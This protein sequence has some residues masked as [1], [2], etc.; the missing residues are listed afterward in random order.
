MAAEGNAQALDNGDTF[1]DWGVLG[2]FSE[3]DAGGTS[4]STPACPAGTARTAA[5]AP[6]GSAHPGHEPHG[7]RAVQQRRD[8]HGA[9]H[10]GTAPRRSPPGRCSGETPRA[11]SAPS[12]ARRGTGCTPRS[13]SR[14]SWSTIRS[15][16]L[17]ATGSAI[18]RAPRLAAPP[19]FSAQP[20]SQVVASGSTVVFSVAS[21]GPAATYQWMLNGSPLSDGAS[22]ETTVS[23][24]AGPPSSSAARPRAMRAPTPASRRTRAV[25]DERRRDPVPERHDRR[26]PA[27]QRL[28]P[29]AGRDGLQRPDHRLRG[30]RPAGVRHA[31]RTAPGLRARARRV[32][33]RRNPARPR[34]CPVRLRRGADLRGGL[35]R[36]PGG[37]GRLRGRRRVPLVRSSSLD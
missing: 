25:G 13:S 11:A 10:T 33:R 26:G 30:G 18:G 24:S 37:L 31:T 32:R 27:G 4:S 15:W 6:P 36:K 12:R 22:G 23:G 35:G 29:G 9:R 2:R 14:A 17:D 34:A 19:T 21:N 20:V 7:G 1:V 5:T 3:F 8:D 16:A 28:L